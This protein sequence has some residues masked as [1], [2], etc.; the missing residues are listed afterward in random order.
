M[1]RNLFHDESSIAERERIAL[2]I[3]AVVAP[4]RDHLVTDD[5]AVCDGYRLRARSL[6]DGLD[7]AVVPFPDLLAS[8]AAAR[9]ELEL[10]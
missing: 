10:A 7:T 9:A 1:K 8:L 3:Q 6:L 4:Y 2:Q 5:P